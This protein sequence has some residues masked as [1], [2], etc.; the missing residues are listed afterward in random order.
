MSRGCSAARR[1][2]LGLVNHCAGVGVLFSQTEAAIVTRS[3]T[4]MIATDAPA[5]TCTHSLA[6]IFEAVKT[7]S[8]ARPLRRYLNR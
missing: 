4:A 2:G 8:V 3:T 7:S 5:L 6:T 1:D